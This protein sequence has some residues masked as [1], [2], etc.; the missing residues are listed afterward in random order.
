[1][2]WIYKIKRWI[3]A[4]KNWLVLMTLFA[5]SY[6]LG[7]KSN[8]NYLE[9]A[10][11]AKDQ[12]KKENE[13]ILRQQKLKEMRDNTAKSKARKVKKALEAEKE[14]RLKEMEKQKVDPDDVFKNI[15]ITKNEINK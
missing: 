1:M 12:Y 15:G 2:I 8:K 14:K 4:H 11:L 6:I 3:V 5:L 9:M 10:K 7:K 13:E